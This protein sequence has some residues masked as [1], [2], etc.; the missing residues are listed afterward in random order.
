MSCCS[1]LHISNFLTVRLTIV[2]LHY[3]R[4]RFL[5]FYR[6]A[7][8]SGL[9]AGEWDHEVMLQVLETEDYPMIWPLPC[10]FPSAPRIPA[11]IR[12]IHVSEFTADQLV[13][14]TV[15]GIS[16]PYSREHD[17]SGWHD[18]L[19]IVEYRAVFDD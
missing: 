8:P 7:K 6:D 14:Y 9:S 1:A 16:T 17:D 12:L 18:E 13:P 15:P 11:L 10:P 5:S 4:N 19:L 2:G 3:V